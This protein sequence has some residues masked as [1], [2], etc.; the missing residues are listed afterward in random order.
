MHRWKETGVVGVPHAFDGGLH[1]GQTLTLNPGE[2]ITIDYDQ[3]PQWMWKG[4][5]G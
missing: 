1:R 4:L 3:P 2:S 5:L